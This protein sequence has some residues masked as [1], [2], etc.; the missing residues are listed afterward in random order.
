MDGQTDGQ[1]IYNRRF[2]S[3]KILQLIK[4]AAQL[5]FVATATAYCQQI[6]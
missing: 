1:Q 5:V 4:K 2:T 3:Q 6:E